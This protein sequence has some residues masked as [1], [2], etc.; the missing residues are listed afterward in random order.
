MKSNSCSEL[1]SAHCALNKYIQ[2]S[3]C[4]FKLLPTHF[5]ICSYQMPKMSFFLH[6]SLALKCRI[7][8]HY[9]FLVYKSCGE[10]SLLKFR[11]SEK[12]IE[13]QKNISPFFLNYLVMSKQI[14]NYFSKFCGVLRISEL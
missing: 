9:I 7:Q 3:H 8:S 11:F 5:K 1:I 10:L 4:P 2:F 6:L 12:A 14:G 13:F